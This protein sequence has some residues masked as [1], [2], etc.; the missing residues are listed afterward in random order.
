MSEKLLEDILN[1]SIYKVI[2]DSSPIG[3]MIISTDGNI[4]TV[5]P[6]VC[7][8]TGYS[9]KELVG[10]STKIFNSGETKKEVY[11]SLWSTIQNRKEWIGEVMNKKKDGNVYPERLSIGPIFNGENVVAYVAHK[12]DISLEVKQREKM[13]KLATTDT[14]TGLC[15]REPFLDHLVSKLYVANLENTLSALLFLD[16]DGFKEVN[17]GYGHKT[18]DE[19][20][21]NVGK[22]LKDIVKE[23]DLVVRWG[24]DEFIVYLD[25]IRNFKDAEKVANRIIKNIG[26]PF[27]IGGVGLNLGVSIGICN[28]EYITTVDEIITC[29]DDAMY[30]AKVWSKNT[31]ALI[32]PRN[33]LKYVEN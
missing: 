7:E 19:V 27:Y 18:G 4:L 15:K 31:Y 32:N 30:K 3:A 25:S 26:N 33:L 24:G 14:L 8:M 11:E 1:E 21:I 29:A 10:A 16:L 20:L 12:Q 28:N 9:Y 23:K 6:K 5:N 17:D 2:V 22:R 13:E